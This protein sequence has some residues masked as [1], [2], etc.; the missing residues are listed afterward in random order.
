MSVKAREWLGTGGPFC[1]LLGSPFGLTLHGSILGNWELSAIPRILS[2][3]ILAIL[4]ILAILTITFSGLHGASSFPESDPQRIQ[5]KP[6]YSA[7]QY[8]YILP[9]TFPRRWYSILATKSNCTVAGWLLGLPLVGL[10]RTH[11]APH[12]I[13]IQAQRGAPQAQ[14]PC[15]GLGTVQSVTAASDDFSG[16]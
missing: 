11:S 1:W 12:P 8:L 2:I 3:L 16:K 9:L 13:R 5:L 14:F 6:Y 4:S 7:V 15:P 10:A